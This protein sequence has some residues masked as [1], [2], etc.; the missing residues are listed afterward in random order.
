VT[1]GRWLGVFPVLLL[2][3][4][5]AVANGWRKDSN[6]LA[7]VN[8]HLGGQVI[9]HTA[10]HGQDNRIW[11]R[12]LYQRRDLYVYLPPGYDRCQRYPLMIWLHGFAQDEQSFLLEVVPA[13]DEA[14][15]A[16]KLPP[17]I[18][19]AP[20]GSLKGEP[21]AFSPG[22]FFL[23]TKA[24]AFHDFVLH[25]VW[26]FVTQHY[27]VRPERG[28]HVL[29]GVSMGGFAAYNFGIRHRDAFGVVV[30]IY[31]PLNLRWVNDKGRYFAN[32]D[33]EH[34]GWRTDLS[35]GHEVIARFYGGL[36]TM[37]IRQVIDPI[38]GRGPE[39]LHEVMRE[40]PIEMVDR[41]GLRN[42]DL[43]MYV[44]YGGK[45]E[46]NIDAQVE[47]F[48]Y[49]MKCRGICIGVGYEPHGRHD[50]STARKLVP[51]I[52]EWLAP[53]IAPYAPCVP[54]AHAPSH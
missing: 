34:W 40:N 51:G 13:L 49:L 2:A 46:F 1:H 31:P 11:S 28:A 43:E 16:G 25:D 6:Q 36:V 41:Y 39:A 54:T 8:Q 35:W 24:G 30:G 17:L 37:K 47:S 21:C 38:F 32:F 4:S 44:A 12:S 48:L 53:R 15:R 52:I 42:G 22:S 45:D 19:V 14:I 33:P 3:V 18:A 10:N 26:D 5:P 50:V 29:A 9:D 20:D 23:N 7:V 27:A